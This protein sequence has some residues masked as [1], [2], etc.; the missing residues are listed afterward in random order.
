MRELELARTLEGTSDAAFAVDLGGEIRTWNKAAAKLFGYQAE[1]V[2]GKACSMVFEGRTGTDLPICRESCHVLTCVQKGRGIPNFD[3]QVNT[4]SGNQKWVNVSILTVTNERIDRRLVVH[5][6]RDIGNRK[7]VEAM[8][9]QILRM[10]RTLVSSINEAEE[11]PPTISLTEQ[12]KKILN[13]L[14]A[15]K[16]SKTIARELKISLSTLRNHLSHINQKLNTR[17]RLGAVLQAIKNGLI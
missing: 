4:R 17:N 8:T 15:G 12:E 6:V 16:T 10:S 9:N 13:L 14:A 2:L 7:H 5:L 1:E 11:A 3:M